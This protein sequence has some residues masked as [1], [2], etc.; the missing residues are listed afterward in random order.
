M[1]NAERRKE[2]ERV[3]TAARSQTQDV[4]ASFLAEACRGD[5][6]LLREVESLLARAGSANTSTET[7]T[8]ADV[9]AARAHDRLAV[10]Q[11]LGSYVIRS[12]LG[13]GGMGEV[14]EAEHLE[15]HR[16]VALKLL[17]HALATSTDRLRFLRE[18]QLAA[19]VNHPNSLYVFGTEDLDGRLAIAMEIATGGTLKDV[20]DR[21]GPMPVSAA[22]D[23]ILQVIAG[24]EAAASAGVL[25]R[26]VKPSNCFVDGDGTVKIGDF[27]LSIA[28]AG[29]ETHLTLTGTLRCTP[30]YAPPEQIRGEALDLRSDVYSVGATLYYLLSGRPPFAND[31]LV[32][33]VANVLQRDADS[34]RRS[35]PDVPE[36]L[37][38]LVLRC[39]AKDP[40]ARPHSYQHLRRDLLPFS[41]Q[42]PVAATPGTRVMAAIVDLVVVSLPFLLADSYL[43]SSV[44]TGV[45]DVPSLSRQGADLVS[46]ALYFGALEGILGASLGKMLFGI[47]IVGP[48]HGSPG[49]RRALVRAV[50]YLAVPEIP[51]LLL[52]AAGFFMRAAPG[53]AIE[54]IVVMT[55]TAAALLLLFSTARR[56]NGFAGVHDLVSRTRVVR[57]IDSPARE[58]LMMPEF[59]V[60]IDAKA[61]RVGPYAILDGPQAG[62]SA[63][64]VLGYDEVLRR[65]VWIRSHPIGTPAV[66]PARRDLARPG[67]LRWLNGRRTAEEC[68][69]AYDAPEG[70]PFVAACRAR[71]PW[72]AV[73]FWLSDLVHELAAATADDHR[74]VRLDLEHVWI[75]KSGRAVL[76]DF[77]C[78]GLSPREPTGIQPP[79][80]QWTA[81]QKEEFVRRFAAAALLASEADPRRLS[82]SLTSVVGLPRHAHVL[83]KQLEHGQ[84]SGLNA[85]AA[86]LDDILG[87]RAALTR[88]RRT[89]HLALSAAVPVCSV[90]AGLMSNAVGGRF[91]VLA[92]AAP[93]TASLIFMTTFAVWSAALFRGGL[94]LQALGITAVTAAGEEV[95]RPRALLRAVVAWSPCLVFVLAILFSRPWLG[96]GALGVAGAGVALAALTPARGLQD[97]IVGTWL[98]AR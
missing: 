17:H 36:D 74:D 3:Y 65:R 26:D 71:S 9:P 57:A 92:I 53:S 91:T 70:L 68:W 79:S 47:R 85:I 39:L 94:M 1:T 4:L 29:D 55:A 75:T 22:V 35:N 24:L 61:G 52:T 69:D 73:R 5:E 54:R 8:A 32:Q 49:I 6:A 59:R 23:A 90:V 25:H 96:V 62:D 40:A 89:V 44:R 81:S 80:G 64:V 97:R 66:L 16:R 72:S 48:V 28:S 84:L 78:P 76:L 95:S 33:L 2:V 15:T 11:R 13:A 18:G 31:G 88:R 14:Y 77:Q 41:S 21:R 63:G 98:V 93:L 10:G 87:R 37:A 43:P 19:S 82:T 67:R 27:G 46:G 50:V 30:T 83:L 38:D 60:E 34:P 51:L 86:A 42:A 12:R 56:G 58:P 7:R 20:V 45:R